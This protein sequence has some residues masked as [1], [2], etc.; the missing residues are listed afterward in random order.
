MLIGMFLAAC[1]QVDNGER[2]LY[3]KWGETQDEILKEGVYWYNPIS[4]K[5]VQIDVKEIVWKDATAAYTS[6]LQEVKIDFTLAWYPSRDTVNKLYREVGDNYEDKIL[7]PSTFGIIKEVVGKYTAVEM[8]T[9]RDTISAEI[10][11]K[12]GD[13]LGKRYITLAKFDVTNLDFKDDFEKSVESKVIA[14]QLAEKAKN[15]TIRIQEESKQKVIQAEAEAKAMEIK[16]E[17]LSKNKGLIEYEAVQKWDG[18]LPVY[19][20]GDSI[21]FI[22]IAPR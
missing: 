14:T 17:A 19:T 22:N 12:L 21:P 5:I 18:K 15:D 11:K 8:I 13:S 10:S 1:S 2:G 16:S 20:L 9:K 7:Y 3:V 6:D 4:T